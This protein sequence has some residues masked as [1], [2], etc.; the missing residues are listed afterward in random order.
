MASGAA[1]PLGRG[2]RREPQ[3]A[4]TAIEDSPRYPVANHGL[5]MIG[6]MLAAL[7]QVLDSTIANVALPHMQSALGA[8]P[9]TVTW[10]LTSYIIASAVALPL[11]GWLSNRVG[12]RRLFIFSVSGF[13][14]TSMMC[15]M[16]QNLEEMVIFRAMQGVSGAFILP[17]SQS[18]MLDA[19]RP[20]KHA[21]IM[22]L[23]SLGVIVGPIVGPV[24]GGW[25]TENWNWRWIFY[26][27]VPLGVSALSI[28]IAQL[29]KSEQTARPFDFVGFILVAAALAALQMLLDRGPQIDWFD[30]TE[31]WIYLGIILSAI[32]VALLHFIAVDHPLFDRR[33]FADLNF[34][35]AMI[36][37]VAT[38][39]VM[40][41]NMA[42]LPPLL[43]TLLGYDTIDA[44]ILMMPRGIGVLVSMQVA[45][46]LVRRGVDAR[47]LI[48][49]GTAMLGYSLYMMSGW[50]LD[51]DRY[52]I[53]S[54]GIIMGFGTGLA[55]LPINVT[56]FATLAPHLRA[57]GSSL[58]NLFRSVGSSIG[59][60]VMMALFS[61]NVQVSHSDLTSQMDGN[62]AGMMDVS[63][64]ERYQSIGE[65]ALTVVNAEISR[66]AAMVAYIDDF[67]LMMWLAIANIPLVMML[68]VQSRPTFTPPPSGH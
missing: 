24:L 47:L 44:G 23:W 41:A 2:S 34:T 65:T 12:T 13:I 37:M 35:I 61:R 4:S 60:S 18:S 6:T 16:A 3:P 1:S 67:H 39:V 42:L 32:W 8:Q 19:T 59:I 38:G 30:A 29:P 56:A 54:S 14:I 27:N 5:L 48:G 51:V 28:L 26:V 10:V 25:L 55:F 17:L 63:T 53:I 64:V 50:S 7:I 11:T 20:S 66:Q 33:L 58:L 9:D 68:K 57:E 21:Q 62:F 43:Q 31:S 36:F 15:G 45:G 46:W 52:H 22:A 49:T 40:F